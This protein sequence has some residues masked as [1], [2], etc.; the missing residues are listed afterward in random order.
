MDTKIDE[1]KACQI[2]ENHKDVDNY[3]KHLK[4]VLVGDSNVG[5]SSI[6]RSITGLPYMENYDTTIGMDFGVFMLK[7]DDTVIKLQIWDTAGQETFR[8]ITRVSYRAAKWVILVYDTSNRDSFDRLESW[9]KEIHNNKPEDWHIYL[10]ASKADK[11][12]EAQVKFE[13]GVAFAKQNLLDHFTETS[14]KTGKGIKELFT[15]VGKQLY[16][17]TQNKDALLTSSLVSK[18]SSILLRDT[19]ISNN[20]WSEHKESIRISQKSAPMSKKKGWW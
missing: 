13:E 5:K 20:R 18:S 3:Y 19:V 6:L 10:A 16:L 8:T 11:E 9:I 1:L 17:E 12:K 14:A 4:I 15:R 2:E 7:I